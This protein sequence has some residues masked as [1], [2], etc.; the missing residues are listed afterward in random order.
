MNEFYFE[1]LLLRPVKCLFIDRGCSC[2][3][4]NVAATETRRTRVICKNT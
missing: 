2:I 1:K 4:V 3:Y